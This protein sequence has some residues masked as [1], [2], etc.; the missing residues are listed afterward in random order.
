MGLNL[1]YLIGGLALAIILGWCIP[2]RCKFSPLTAPLD[3]SHFW[4]NF[5]K[6]IVIFLFLVALGVGVHIMHDRGDSPSV[7]WIQGIVG[8][9][10][11]LLA[12]LMGGAALARRNQPA[13]PPKDVKND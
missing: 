13:E 10:L 2:R 4:Q 1:Y 6:V 9:L 8:Q 7:A 3:F 5:D 11:S 12:G